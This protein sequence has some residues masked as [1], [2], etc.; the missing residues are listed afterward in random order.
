MS[1]ELGEF[2]KKTADEKG[3]SLREVARRSGVPHATVQKMCGKHA[4]TARIS[5]LEKIATGTGVSLKT[6]KELAANTSGY[7]NTPVRT[8]DMDQVIASIHD[9]NDDQV[10]QV[11]ALVEAMIKTG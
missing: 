9:L 10:S 6:L 2:I 3:W 1:N 11:K 4:G 8:G 7:T 5:T